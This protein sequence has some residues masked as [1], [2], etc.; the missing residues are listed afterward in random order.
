MTSEVG[1]NDATTSSDMNLSG[2]VGH[3]T[4]FS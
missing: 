1:T 3:V 2:K 4:I